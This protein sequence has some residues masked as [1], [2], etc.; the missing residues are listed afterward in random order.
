MRPD[1]LGRQAPQGVHDRAWRAVGVHAGAQVQ[2]DR[3][4]AAQVAALALAAGALFGDVGVRVMSILAP[5]GGRRCSSMAAAAADFMADLSAAS[6]SRPTTV[7]V[8]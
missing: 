2:V 7:P 3:S 1:G 4:P 8:W 6:N 5:L